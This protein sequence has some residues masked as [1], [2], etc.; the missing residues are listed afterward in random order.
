MKVLNIQDYLVHCE[1]RETK[2]V[3]IKKLSMTAKKNTVDTLT[4][5]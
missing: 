3:T 4:K 1:I 5:C 2:D